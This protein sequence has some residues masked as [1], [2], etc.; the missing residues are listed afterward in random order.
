MRDKM[1]FLERIDMKIGLSHLEH[2]ENIL[3]LELQRD[4]SKGYIVSEE[5]LKL[6]TRIEWLV[7]LRLMT[8]LP[9]ISSKMQHYFYCLHCILSYGLRS[10]CQ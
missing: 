3:R 4:V 8:I 10:L 5:K 2:H 1:A 7:I 6:P 9:A